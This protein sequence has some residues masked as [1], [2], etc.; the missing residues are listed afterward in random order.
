MIGAP[1]AVAE[2]V[3][4]SATVEESVPTATPFPSVG[5]D[6][7]VS[8]FPLPVAASTTVAP[9]TGLANSSVTVTVIVEVPLPTMIVLGLAVTVDTSVS[10]GPASTVMSGFSVIGTPPAVAEM[11]FCSAF[12]EEI[13]PVATPLASVG[14]AG[15]VMSLSLPVDDSTTVTSLTG[16]PLASLAVTVIVDVLVP[17]LALIVVGAALTEDWDAETPLGGWP[18]IGWQ[19]VLP[20][21]VKV[22]PAT[23]TNLQ[24]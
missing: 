10:G 12:V 15:C 14:P 24:A 11:V 3:F 23:G 21:S 16:S 13:V 9:L 18:G 5:P 4:S 2:T 6:G 19:A 22:W 20:E 17:L 1:P 7:W 8:V